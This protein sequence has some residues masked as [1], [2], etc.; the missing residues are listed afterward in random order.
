METHALLAAWY[1]SARDVMTPSSTSQTISSMDWYVFSSPL[2]S[3]TR[4]TV[5]R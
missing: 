5:G 2:G 1:I 3:R 4:Y